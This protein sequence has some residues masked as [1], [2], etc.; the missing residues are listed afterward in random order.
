MTFDQI[1]VFAILGSLLGFFVWGYLRYDVVALLGLLVAV[2]L[3]VVPVDQAF[4]GFGHPAI[5]TVAA[6]LV[7]SRAL[8]N[9][10]A[11]DRL[12]RTIAP[13]TGTTVFHIAALA[14]VAAALSAF[15][16]NV[17]A[18][19]LLLPVALQ[20]AASAGRSPA[21]ILMPL[22]FGSILGGLMTLIGTPPNIIVATYRQTVAGEP[23]AMFDFTPVGAA[24]AGLGL[25][26]LALAGWRLVPK[27]RQA[28]RAAEDL[29]EVEGYLTEVRVPNE[30]KAVGMIASDVENAV[31][32]DELL[33]LGLIRRKQRMFAAARREKIRAGDVL[34][35]EAMP[36]AI[37]KLVAA[38][39]VKLVGGK[40][41]GR[42]ELRAD[43]V[44]LVEAVV[45]P[46]SRIE[47]RVAR[48]LRLRSR[49]SANLVAISRQGR[50]LHER[51]METRF[52][53]GDVL[54]LQGDV[55]RM[56][57]TLAWL[58][59]LPLAGRGLQLGKRSQVGLAVG[60]FAAA[61]IAAALGLVPLL[62]ALALAM[63]AVV[64]LNIVPAREA[65]DA[66]D[67]PVI[68]LLGALIPVG[69]ALE[70]TGGTALL[71]AGITDLAAGVSPVVILVLLMIV[72]MTLSDVMNNAA[73]AVVMAPV[74]YRIA[75]QLA[76]NPDPFLMA[77]AVGASCAFLTPIGHQNNMLVMGPG[78]YRFGDYW[79]MGLP[80][81]GLIVVV[82][83]PMILWVWPL[84]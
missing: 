1:A 19:A 23:F 84:H 78:G 24:V 32:D 6:V 13:A 36:K 64:V 57:E 18:L 56:P 4:S 28:R 39:G 47:G 52:R 38:L 60:I 79:R 81:E 45:Q 12:V 11:I 9:S 34:I 66:I 61:I 22:S 31:G 7:I 53:A 48:D 50:P 55:D 42:G 58:G 82:A 65:Y 75:E 17:G 35:V 10:G 20:S 77:V 72:T 49:H 70:T 33:V 69:G 41:F 59:C 29:F 30:S 14:G 54:L 68:V 44:I 21:L 27:E 3:G 62:L 73:T 37:D 74:G 26:F 76:V 2:V 15:M 80:L 51:L 71:A 63:A 67:W 46:R 5:I 83:V 25:V 43:D 8:T 40:D 16:N